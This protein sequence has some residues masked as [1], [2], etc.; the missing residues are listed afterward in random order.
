MTAGATAW[1]SFSWSCADN[2]G[3]AAGLVYS[4]TTTWGRLCTTYGRTQR[5]LRPSID[6]RG[7]LSPRHGR[8]ELLERRQG[9]TQCRADTTAGATM[10]TSAQPCARPKGPERRRVASAPRAHDRYYYGGDARRRLEPGPRPQQPPRRAAACTR[11][12]RRQSRGRSTIVSSPLTTQSALARRR[13]DGA[14]RPHD[15]PRR[16]LGPRRPRTQR[17]GQRVQR[18]RQ[19][20]TRRRRPRR[21]NR[22]DAGPTAR[23]AQ[24]AVAVSRRPRRP[25]RTKLQPPAAGPALSRRAG[26]DPAQAHARGRRASRLGMPQPV[27]GEAPSRRRRAGRTCRPRA[28]GRAGQIAAAGARR[29]S[30]VYRLMTPGA[31]RGR[32]VQGGITAQTSAGAAAAE[33]LAG[34]LV[35][36]EAPPA[37]CPRRTRSSVVADRVPIGARPRRPIELLGPAHLA[38][39]CSSLDY[40]AR[41]LEVDGG[42]GRRGIEPAPR[43]VRRAAPRRPPRVRADGRAARQDGARCRALVVLLLLLSLPRLWRLDV[44]GRFLRV[45]P[46]FPCNLRMCLPFA[47]CRGVTCL[48]LTTSGIDRL[49]GCCHP[50]TYR[51]WWRRHGHQDFVNA[52]SP[53]LTTPPGSTTACCRHAARQ[54]SH[55]LLPHH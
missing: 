38:P 47:P 50:Q 13:A 36:P 11:G 39:P 7:A 34:R 37:P 44:R 20:P 2:G 26:R 54:L 46:P 55:Q 32:R 49:A 40:Y 29:R 6:N 21:H 52:L 28:G 9:P 12:R 16:R 15:G 8:L 23:A 24:P 31:A 27:R 19:R 25:R 17:R 18:P 43:E 53:R 1:F 51:L 14:P 35:R 45:A 33:V 42:G 5:G 22:D 30:V 4:R 10:T 48:R 3:C 41:A